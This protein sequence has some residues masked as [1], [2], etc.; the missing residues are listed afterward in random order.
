MPRQKWTD[1]VNSLPLSGKAFLKP[2]ALFWKTPDCVCLCGPP[3]CTPSEERNRR[4]SQ[5]GV[6]R[7]SVC[8]IRKIT[9]WRYI[10]MTVWL[11]PSAVVNHPDTVIISVAYFQFLSVFI[12]RRIAQV[13]LKR[14]VHILPFLRGLIGERSF[15]SVLFIILLLLPFRHRKAADPP[16]AYHPSARRFSIRKDRLW[17]HPILECR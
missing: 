14:K 3:F 13:F 7:E 11:A 17:L 1:C 9:G 4:C 12:L 8:E 6:S 15:G 16:S 10:H 2:T 5:G